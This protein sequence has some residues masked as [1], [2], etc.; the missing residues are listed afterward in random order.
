MANLGSS[1]RAALLL[2]LISGAEILSSETARGEVVA[3]A[4]PEAPTEAATEAPL[5]ASLVIAPPP[6]VAAMAGRLVGHRF[7][8]GDHAL[9]LA[10]VAGAGRPWV[11]VVA[12]RC[13]GLWLD[14]AVA[15]LRLTGPLARP[16]LAGPGYLMWAIGRVSPDRSLAL[17]RLG[18]LARPA[19]VPR[20]RPPPAAGIAP[21]PPP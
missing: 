14:T 13:G 18:V 17:H 3:Q 7:F 2:L 10:D 19:E 11:G 16:R 9:I 20:D 5:E 6:L 4:A 8:V 1:A 12:A 15:S 21:C